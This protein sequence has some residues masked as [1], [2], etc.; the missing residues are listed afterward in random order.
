M[1]GVTTTVIQTDGSTSLTEVANQFD[2]DGTG[3]SGPALQYAGA[4]V[5][6]GQF[7]AWTPIGA[8]QTATGYDVA[9]KNT[10]S[11]QYMVWATDSN[12]N[13]AGNLIGAVAGNG[14]TLESFETVF[15]QDLNGD[16][17]TGLN[18]TVIQT[19]SSSF[20]STS[21]GKIGNNY[22]L[23]AAGGTTGPHLQ[24]NGAA[25][26]TGQFGSWM[27]IGAVQTANGYDIAWKNTSTGHY[28]VWTT[29]NNGNYTGNMIGEVS[30]NSSTLESFETLFNQDLNSDGVLGLY[31]AAGGTLKVSTALAASSGDVTIGIGAT[32]ELKAADAASVTFQGSTGTLR[33]DQPSTF[34]AEIFGFTGNGSLSGSDQ[35]DLKGINY[36]TVADS[37]A[38]GI[39]TVTDGTGDTAKLSF[40]GSY[41]LANFDFASDGAG[42]TIVYDPPV[43]GTSGQSASTPF[44]ANVAL[45]RNYMASSFAASCNN[46]G[47][48]M[49]TA[50]AA[51]SS[52]QSV[53]SNPHHA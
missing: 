34:K 37:Y 1:I 52:Y 42:G 15:N 25:V 12:G 46:A 53:L 14:Y 17:V 27:P 33:L 51:Q 19:D 24:Y 20:G 38:N 41:S 47:V 3:G 5:T 35:I 48:T 39:L 13:Y 6:A 18:P 32:L 8:V 22:L 40:N 2:L 50:E 16:G 30:G 7:G 10:A 36:N 43:P 4:D 28:T 31:A 45:L 26:T 23:F 11:G 29:D 44:V 49:L 9:W 21:L